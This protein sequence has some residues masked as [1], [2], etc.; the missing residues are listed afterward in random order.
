MKVLVLGAGVIGAVYGSQLVEAGHS[1]SVL[2]HGASTNNVAREGL[3]VRDVTK[4]I[5]Q[6]AHVTPVAVV[7]ESADR[8]ELVLVCV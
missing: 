5:A 4:N 3:V 1:V 6:A 8:Y 2:E 7:S